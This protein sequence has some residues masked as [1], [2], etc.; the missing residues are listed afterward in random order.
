M[1]GKIECQNCCSDQIKARSEFIGVCEECEELV[2]LR[3]KKEEKTTG[4]EKLIEALTILSKYN[5]DNFPTNCS[6]DL[7]YVSVDDISVVTD[8]DLSRLLDLEFSI[9]EDDGFESFYFGSC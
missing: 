4:L 7:F 1:S 8:E 2:S 9:H 6:H 5:K 3:V